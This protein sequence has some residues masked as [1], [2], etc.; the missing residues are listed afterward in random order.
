MGSLFPLSLLFFLAA[1]Y[2][3]VG[4]ALGCR[5]KRAQGPKGSPLAPSGTSVPFWVRVSP[6]FVAVP[7]GKSVWLNCSNSCPQPQ[8]SSLRTRLRQGKTSRGPGWVSYQ[9]L[10][11]RAWSSHAH[12]LVTCAGKTRWAT[13]RITAYKPPHSVILEPPVLKGRKYTLRCHVTQVFPV[14]YLVVT[15]R[16]GS[17]VIYS[18]SLERFTGLDPANVTLTYEFPAGPLDFWQPVICHARL[19]LDGLVVR[20]SSAPITLMLAWSP[21]PTALA[22]GSIAALVGILLT[23]GAA[24]LCKCLA[25][26]SQA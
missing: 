16:H 11:V 24:F 26:K 3:G 14:G 18:E 10:D 15:L 21:A 8:N 23:V 12:C 1:A 4:S 6:E 17:R 19:N 7:P 25:M 2:P 13:A 22:S 9:L 20:N 5:T